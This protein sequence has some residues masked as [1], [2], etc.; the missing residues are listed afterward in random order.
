MLKKIFISIMMFA[1]ALTPTLASAA[2]VS[3]KGNATPEQLESAAKELEYIFTKIIV[4]NEATG[5]Y[6]V[7]VQ[8]FM[9]SK[10]SKEEKQGMLNFVVTMNGDES[11]TTYYASRS[12]WERCWAEAVGIG[13]DA[14]SE[15][16]EY[17][18]KKQWIAAAG[19]LGFLGLAIQPATIFIFSLQC[20][21]SPAGIRANE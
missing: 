10:Y 7:N 6:D 13:R 14:L 12:A 20:G 4:K 17:V 1:L 21:P 18:E 8:E 9:K 3:D 19:I 15:F 11:K 2:T 5:K 16:F